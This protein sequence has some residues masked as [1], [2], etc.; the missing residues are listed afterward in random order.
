MERY[1]PEDLFWSIV[2]PRLVLPM[3]VM[4]YVLGLLT[5]IGHTQVKPHRERGQTGLVSSMRQGGPPR[6]SGASDFTNA[7]A[8]P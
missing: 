2:L 7:G 8:S 1:I 4:S 6:K 3:D 5:D